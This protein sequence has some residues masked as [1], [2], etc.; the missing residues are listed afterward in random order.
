MINKIIRVVL[1][2]LN[3][4]D[5]KLTYNNE[6]E[7]VMAYMKN[8]WIRKDINVERRAAAVISKLIVVWLAI[9]GIKIY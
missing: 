1:L 8:C 5:T 7:A 3:I 4:T 2:L 6:L 9:V